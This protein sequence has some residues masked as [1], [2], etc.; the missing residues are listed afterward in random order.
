MEEEINNQIEEN[1][2]SSMEIKSF[3]Y[4]EWQRSLWEDLTLEEV[5]EHAKN[6]QEKHK[7]PDEV[8]EI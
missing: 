6:A 7:V 5:F 8:D 1:D 3:N 4:T 2:K